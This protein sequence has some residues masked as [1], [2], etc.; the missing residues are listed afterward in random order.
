MRENTGLATRKAVRRIARVA[1]LLA[2]LLGPGKAAAQAPE[3]ATRVRILLVYDMGGDEKERERRVVNRAAVERALETALRKQGLGRRYTLDILAGPGATRQAVLDRYQALRTGPSEALLFYSNAHGNTDPKRGHY[4]SL[5]GKRLY[6]SDLRRAMTAEA[7]PRRHPHRRLREPSGEGA[8]EQ[9]HR[10]REGPEGASGAEGG[11]RVGP[12][13][14]AVPAR[15]G[16]GHQR[17]RAGTVLLRQHQP[18]QLLHPGAGGAAGPA[19]LPVRL[20]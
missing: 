12:A 5:G 18:G 2:A 4:L 11:G 16:G 1:V 9:D 10:H 20:Q 3:E 7:A 15:G 17:G 14:P 19:G 13:G 8:A 6:R